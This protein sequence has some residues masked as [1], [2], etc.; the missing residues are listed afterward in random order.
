MNFLAGQ[1]FIILAGQN[2][3]ITNESTYLCSFLIS[4]IHVITPIKWSKV[5]EVLNKCFY[6]VHQFPILFWYNI[7]QYY[8]WFRRPEFWN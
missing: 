1:C 8:A 7:F 3:Y 6:G 4:I 5:N 2:V